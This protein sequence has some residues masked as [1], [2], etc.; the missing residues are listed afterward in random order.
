M[1]FFYELKKKITL[2][3]YSRN[4]GKGRKLVLQT[5]IFQMVTPTFGIILEFL[6]TI[7]MDIR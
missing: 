1:Q 6:E 2:K 4:K 5:F 7:F 3:T